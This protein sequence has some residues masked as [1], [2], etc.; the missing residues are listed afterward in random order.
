MRRLFLSLVLSAF[1]ATACD[2]GGGDD[3]LSRLTPD[4]AARPSPLVFDTVPIGVTATAAVTLSNVGD[5]PLELGG[6]RLEAG[7]HPDLALEAGEPA[8]TLQPGAEARVTVRFTPSALGDVAGALLVDSSDPDT[9]TLRVPIL[10]TRR[11]GPVLV[12]CTESLEVPLARRCART[13]DLDLGAVPVG[14]YRE[15]TVELRSE[16][17]DPLVV[18]AAG[19]SADTHPSLALV[20]T[21]TRALAPGEFVRLPLRFTPSAEGPVAGVLEVSSSDG[22]RAIAIAGRGVEPS[23]CVRPA[24]LD[25]GAVALDGVATGTV[26]AANCGD[27][28]LSLTAVT[29]LGGPGPFALLRPLTRPLTLAPIAG[30]SYQAGLRFTATELGTREARVR[31]ESDR[32]VSVITARARASECELEVAPAQLEFSPR[33]WQQTLLISN[34]GSD[35]CRIRRLVITDDGDG[36]FAMG[37]LAPT[38]ATLRPG[39]SLEV[40]L[41]GVGSDPA[42]DEIPGLLEVVHGEEVEATTEVPLLFRAFDPNAACLLRA[43]PTSLQFGPVAPGSERAIGLALVNEGDGRCTLTSA[44]MT[45]DSAPAFSVEAPANLRIAPFDSALVKVWFRPTEAAGPLTGTVRFGHDPMDPEALDVPVSGFADGPSLCVT[46]PF[47]DFGLTQV[48]AQRSLELFACGTRAVTIEHVLWATQDLEFTLPEP[49]PLPLTLA[50]GERRTVEV[51][52]A[53]TDADGDTAVLRFASDD[54]ARPRLDVR[55]TGGAQVVPPEAGRFLYLWQIDVG[56]NTGLQLSEVSRMPLQGNLAVEPFAGP[57]TGRGCVGCHSLSPDGRYV[58]FIESEAGARTLRVLDTS[59]Q[60][61]ALLPAEVGSGLF[62][63][64]RPDVNSDPPY[65]FAFATPE[66]D[67][68]TSSLFTGFIG[69][70]AGADGAEFE[71][72]P[73]WSAGGVIAFVRGLDT[74]QGRIWTVPEAGGVAAP[75]A[76][77]DRGGGSRYYPHFSP[78]GRW[79]AHT[80]SPQGMSSLGAQDARLEVVAAD[81]S[82]TLLTYPEVNL[83]GSAHSYPTWSVDGRYLSFS[84]NRPGGAGSWDVYLVPFDPATGAVGAVRPIEGLNNAD[85][86]HAAQWS[87]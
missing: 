43:L 34:A 11:Q 36:T 12:V 50:P 28:D 54:G 13:L 81:G 80:Y 62:V 61:E 3:G 1:T 46:P 59:T 87:P 60:I 66:G 49:L 64:W 42:L 68:A 52:Y 35:A 9:P 33:L 10:A 39:E 77:G 16:G 45:A 67:I 38:D 48:T 56:N 78:D 8:G 24:L 30:V 15:A 5:F 32:G 86:Q 55:I 47:L 82:G 19:L 72:M 76:G 27:V 29:V 83:P 70:V 37:G 40:Q 23:L 75:L 51:L 6:L 21:A 14:E 20:S 26:A 53:P 57:R 65:Q 25:L 79:I 2:C 18:S 7:S 84:S 31:F 58:A 85:Y 74:N 71:T 41:S 69:E 4:L 73:S 63:S 44:A 22:P 17:T